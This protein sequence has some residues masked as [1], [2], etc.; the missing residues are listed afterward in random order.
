MSVLDSYDPIPI[1]DF[2]GA[3][4]LREPA[5]VRPPFGLA[6]RNV[7]YL[8][9]LVKT[10]RG[11]Y[12]SNLINLVTL[13]GGA[14]PPHY[15]F[16][17]LVGDKSVFL[18]WNGVAN[19]KLIWKVLE[20]GGGGGNYTV[21]AGNNPSRDVH[22]AQWGNKVFLVGCDQIQIADIDPTTGG[23]TMYEGFAPPLTNAEIVPPV[24]TV[25]AG[26]DM[27]IGIHRYGFIF[28]TK[29]GHLTKFSPRNASVLGSF[30]HVNLSVGS[31]NQKASIQV[32]PLANWAAHLEKT[33]LVMT[34]VSNYAR[35]YIVAEADVPVG[36][37]TTITFPDVTVSDGVMAQ[38]DDVFYL[39]D[40]LATRGG[41]PSQQFMYPIS[42]FAASDRMA[43]V[44]RSNENTGPV[45]APGL[46]IGGG[47]MVSEPGRPEQLFAD[48]SMVQMPSGRDPL[49]GWSWQGT[50]YIGGENFTA[51]TQ[52]TGG[53][54]ATWPAPRIIDD[55]IGPSH[56]HGV[57]TNPS[58][59]AYVAHRSGLYLFSGG[60]YNRIPLSY[61]QQPLWDQINWDGQFSICDFQ[62]E[63]L[64]MVVCQL[65]DTTTRILVWDYTD[66][67]TA[68]AM[69]YSEW[70][71]ALYTPTYALRVLTKGDS[72]ENW[73]HNQLWLLTTDTIAPVYVRRDDS[74]G[75]LYVDGF[76]LRIDSEMRTAYLGVTEAG[77]VNSYHGIRL[78][79]TGQGNLTATLT[80]LDGGNA[81]VLNPIALSTVPGRF[82]DR[83]ASLRSEGCSIT[84]VNG[85]TAGDYF[86]LGKAALFSSLYAVKRP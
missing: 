54:P 86:V 70:S 48:L 72:T 45:G 63:R 13:G 7:E 5:D 50:I 80:A 42:C 40:T 17:A 11:F 16:N 43:Y 60:V 34:T 38:G 8:P 22:M 30:L 47:V 81:K 82:H 44:L 79:A 46:V 76:S 33:Y 83:L 35:Y 62:D 12:N 20:S 10:R 49:I 27:T 85:A 1:D 57:A 6:S 52:D 56:V 2:R 15:G 69:K 28:L 21:N 36:T 19:D 68:D 64:L 53:Y 73:E 32:Q 55:A 66:G 58:G 23:V 31:S 84:L 29:T 71:T 14:V 75:S 78:R 24:A 18:G 9:G 39:E 61:Y 41:S 59:R 77:V 65:R 67:I 25:A 26:G 51:A 37:M 4:L 3:D 74:A